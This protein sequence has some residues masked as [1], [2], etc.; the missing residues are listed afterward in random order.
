M[1]CTAR[2]EQEKESRR[3]RVVDFAKKGQDQPQPTR[4]KV[5]L[6]KPVSGVLP[7]SHGGAGNPPVGDILYASGGFV[8]SPSP[9]PAP[10]RHHYDYLVT[11]QGKFKLVPVDENEQ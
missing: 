6:E 8:V 9:A 5:N 10:V 1:S 7:V 3:I 2:Y 11:K 4:G